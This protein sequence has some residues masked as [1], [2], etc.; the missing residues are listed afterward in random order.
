M[1]QTI[2]EVELFPYT[3]TPQDWVPC[4]GRTLNRAQ[5]QALYA[6][7]GNQYG[8]DGM[9]TFCVPNL[10]GTEPIPNTK[11]YMAVNG[12]FPVRY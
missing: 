6:L 10:L 4:D 11:Y 1:D 8:G 12:I 9:N 2:G 5:Y 7:I 3:F